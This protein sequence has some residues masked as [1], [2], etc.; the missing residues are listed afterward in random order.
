M[1]LERGTSS[2]PQVRQGALGSRVGAVKVKRERMEVPRRW[3]SGVMRE[4]RLVG[5]MIGVVAL[6][7]MTGRGEVTET[8]LIFRVVVRGLVR[9]GVRESD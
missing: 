3:E 4:G 2:S 7:W 8:V 9:G 6:R 1:D 5:D